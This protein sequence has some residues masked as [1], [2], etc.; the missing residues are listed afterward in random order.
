MRL[1][2]PV[3]AGV[4]Y[5]TGGGVQD[6]DQ[7]H[8]LRPAGLRA[9]QQSKPKVTAVSTPQQLLDAVSRGD[10]HIEIRQ[11]LNRT[12]VVPLRPP[13]VD[14]FPAT[15]LSGPTTVQGIRVRHFRMPLMHC[16][17]NDR[18]AGYMWTVMLTSRSPSGLTSCYGRIAG[19]RSQD[20]HFHVNPSGTVD[21][22]GAC[23]CR[24]TAQGRLPP[25]PPWASLASLCCP[26]CHTSAS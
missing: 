7:G 1:Y 20:L 13:L 10:D 3:T 5:S 2:S 15:I 26:S 6:S 25:P 9:L 4:H 19:A 14:G 12:A 21:V 23:A 22:S 24:A 18:Q 17:G 11:H 16:V 8:A